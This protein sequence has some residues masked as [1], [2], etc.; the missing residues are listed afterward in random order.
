MIRPIPLHEIVLFVLSLTAVAALAAEPPAATDGT[1][2]TTDEAL[3][4]SLL[5]D[6]E[7]GPDD[8][9]L[10]R[11]DET[12]PSN[13]APTSEPGEQ[14]NG[15]G[16]VVDPVAMSRLMAGL[17]IAE[18]H[19]AEGETGETTQAAQSNVIA[20]LARLIDAAEKQSNS[21]SRDQNPSEAPSGSSGNPSGTPMSQPMPGGQGDTESP[22]GVADVPAGSPDRNR[23]GKADESSE[24]G[25][26][27]AA[28]S[29]ALRGFR[30]DLVQDVWGHLPQRLRDQM[31]NAGSDRYLPEYDSLVRQYFESLAQPDTAPG[32]SRP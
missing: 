5:G 7:T 12:A 29:T 2:V 32:A 25:R 31:M 18:Q 20:E 30:S 11:D 21:A 23:E 9:S 3:L 10:N 1:P 24:R 13:P 8:E 26:E 27:E 6:E 22:M 17:K 16:T 28:Q 15:S 19:L 14:G 4:R